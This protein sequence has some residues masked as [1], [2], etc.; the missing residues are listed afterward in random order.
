LLF[1]GDNIVDLGFKAG[2]IN[3]NG[4]IVGVPLIGNGGDG[5]RVFLWT[6]GQAVYLPLA[7]VIPTGINS[8]GDVIGGFVTPQGPQAFLYSGGQMT[9]LGV[10]SHAHAINEE[11]DVVGEEQAGA[12]L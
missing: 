7:G 5:G 2:G 6:G 3:D 12:F 8:K 10:R 4:E 11:G 1:S 9:Y